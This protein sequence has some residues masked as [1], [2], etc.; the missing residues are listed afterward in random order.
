[1]Q[2]SIYQDYKAMAAKGSTSQIIEPRLAI[3]KQRPYGLLYPAV[4]AVPFCGVFL[5]WNRDLA[6]CVLV[7]N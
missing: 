1:M 2:N 5:G 3:G 4:P 7:S 6:C